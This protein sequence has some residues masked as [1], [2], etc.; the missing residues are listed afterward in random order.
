MSEIT[1]KE[2]CQQLKRKHLIWHWQKSQYNL[3]FHTANQQQAY[4]LKSSETNQGV[5]SQ[6]L[7]DRIQTYT[8]EGN[9]YTITTHFYSDKVSKIFLEVVGRY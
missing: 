4:W 5:F 3:T 8:K 1:L 2:L 6:M 9:V 7:N